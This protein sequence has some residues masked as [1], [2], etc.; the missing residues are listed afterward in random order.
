MSVDAHSSYEV[1]I[2]LEVHTQL[3]TESKLFCGCR[4]RYG[5][6]PN[7]HACPVCLALPGALPVLNARAVEFGVRTALAMNCTVHPRSVFARKNYFYPDLP[8]GYQISQYEEPLATKGWIEIDGEEPGGRSFAKRIGITRI[9]MEEDAGKSI[10]DAAANGRNGSQVDLNRAGVPLLEIVSEPDLRSPAEAGA[11]LRTLR[12]LLRYVDVSDGDMEKGH[13]RCDANVSLRK[14]GAQELGIRN[15]IKNLNSFRFV[16]DAIRTEIERQARVLDDGGRIIQAT[17]LYDSA[18]GKT[19]V[20]R[21][22]ENADDYRYFPD[23]DLVPLALE[24]AVVERARLTL[25][26]LPERRRIRFESEHGL[27]A[28]DARLLSVSRSLADFFEAVVAARVPAKTAANWILRDVLQA[29]KEREQEIEETKLT[30]EALAALLRLLEEGR[31][32]AKSARELLPELV[33][34]G[35]DPAELVSVR[36]L[37]AVSDSAQIERAA[38]EVIAA[39][40]ENAQRFRAGEEKILNFLMGQVMKKTGGKASPAVVRDILARKLKA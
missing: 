18:T 35:G 37:E 14:K 16:E 13:F 21:T 8:K 22:K 26:E 36:G 15:E 11:Y 9:H 34:H 10:H 12:Q 33:E 3:R 19:R 30:P 2:G 25:P 39:H 17:R 1:V 23:P 6:D 40:P 5:D 7:H 27:S 32:T 24:A 20:M 38:D 29:L 28:Y 4:V 31:I